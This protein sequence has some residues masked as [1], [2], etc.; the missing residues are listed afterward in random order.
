MGDPA[1]PCGSSMLREKGG[2]LRSS[3]ARARTCLI[4]DVNDCAPMIRRDLR[5]VC[6]RICSGATES[7][8]HT[9]GHCAREAVAAGERQLAEAWLSSTCSRG[10]RWGCRDLAELRHRSGGPAQ[11]TR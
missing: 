8:W 1:G 7:L 6:P 10:C 2:H 9:C 5:G 4:G 11:V 3:P